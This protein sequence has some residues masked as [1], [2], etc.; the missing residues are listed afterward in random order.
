M[1]P[2]ASEPPSATR[3]AQSKLDT[4]TLPRPRRPSSHAR[5]L[6]LLLLV[7]AVPTAAVWWLGAVEAS[8]RTR[9]ANLEGER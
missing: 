9:L 7:L 4:A 3:A 8:F 6:R 1:T 5:L 2:Y